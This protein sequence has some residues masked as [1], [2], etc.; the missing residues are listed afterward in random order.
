LLVGLLA[1]PGTSR[2]EEIS[3]KVENY[4]FAASEALDDGEPALALSLL[5]RAKAEEPDCCILEEYLCRTYM[6]LGNLELAR[7][8]YGNFATCMKSSD[9]SVLQELDQLL[10]VAEEVQRTA[11]A[12]P[13]P[14]PVAVAPTPAD[15]PAVADSA[16][17]GAPEKRGY[18]G[19]GAGWVVAGIGSA[20]AIS[21]GVT[22]RL[23]WQ[24]GQEHVELGSRAAYEDLLGLNHAAVILTGVGGGLVATGVIME[25]V[26]ARRGRARNETRTAQLIL[27]PTAVGLSLKR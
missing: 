22:A 4:I 27:Q 20:A 18:P 19:R 3:L 5:R 10:L 12:V 24:R 16:E 9:E 14:E 23:S 7:Q 21:F 25:I 26:L 2:A 8:S 13:E 17:D 6:E 11:A 1:G 15:E